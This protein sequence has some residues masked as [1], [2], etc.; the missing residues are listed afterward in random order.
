MYMKTLLGA[1]GLKGPRV[2]G[3]FAT[4]VLLASAAM[5]QQPAARISREIDNSEHAIIRGTHPP[6]AR[7]ENEV[8][9]VPPG[10][11]LQGISIV[12]SHTAAQEA[13]LQN[14]IAAQQDRT[15]PLYHKWLTPDEFAAR[16]GVGDADI[17]S[18][19][20]WLEQQGFSID[21]VSRGTKR[22][23]FSGTVQQAEAAFGTELHYYDVGGKKHYA[24]SADISEIGRAHV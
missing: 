20:S 1:H 24:P 7:A 11:K 6:M 19:Q 9:R 2:A 4:L 15:S 3:C 17:A 14:L 22:I 16:F 12:F 10:I 5:A 8:G 21:G 18:V 23:S 13:D